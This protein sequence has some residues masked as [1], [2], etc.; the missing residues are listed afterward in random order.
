M[1]N[2][3]AVHLH[4]TS[5]CAN[6]TAALDP[7]FDDLVESGVVSCEETGGYSY[8]EQHALYADAWWKWGAFRDM[9]KIEAKTSRPL[10]ARREAAPR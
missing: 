1:T 6:N 8:F 9:T 10:G 4:N 2:L 5:I 3:R 7:A